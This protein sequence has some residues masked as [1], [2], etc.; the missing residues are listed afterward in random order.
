[1]NALANADILHGYGNGKFGPNDTMTWAHVYYVMFGLL[2]IDGKYLPETL[3]EDGVVTFDTKADIVDQVLGI[4]PH[5]SSYNQPI[6]RAEATMLVTLVYSLAAG[7]YYDGAYKF[8]KEHNYYD[9]YTSA[10]VLAEKAVANGNKKWTIA[11]IPDGKL[12]KSLVDGTQSDGKGAN[13]IEYA[14]TL[15]IVKGMDSKGTLNAAGNLTRAQ[16]CQ[17]LYNAGIL[18]CVYPIFIGTA[19]SY[20]LWCYLNAHYTDGTVNPDFDA[21]LPGYGGNIG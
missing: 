7:N 8:Y 12:A 15:G 10:K 4:T 1:M 2:G 16:F 6:N 3:R 11:D 14:Y 18:G 13:L 21:G 19:R 17:M 9:R 5:F 20:S